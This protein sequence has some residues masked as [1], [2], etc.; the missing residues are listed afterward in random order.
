M[1]NCGKLIF[2]LGRTILPRKNSRIYEYQMEAMSVP[3]LLTTTWR[4]RVRVGGPHTKAGPPRGVRTPNGRPKA[5]AGQR[6]LGP[7]CGQVRPA[8][9][10][11]LSAGVAKNGGGGP[12]ARREKRSDVRSS[13]PPPHPRD[14]RV[15][16]PRRSSCITKIGVGGQKNQTQPPRATEPRQHPPHPRGPPSGQVPLAAIAQERENPRP[17]LGFLRFLHRRNQIRPRAR[18]HQQPEPLR[19]PRGHL[20]RL[21]VVHRNHV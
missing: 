19:Q 14:S 10:G 17:R 9:A 11:P 6:K 7:R 12:R 2:F 5:K 3:L 20:E 4:T 8:S 15:G 21:V 18:P 16:S 1:K 13:H